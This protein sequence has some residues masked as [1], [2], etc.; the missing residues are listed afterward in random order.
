AMPAAKSE[1]RHGPISYSGGHRPRRRQGKQG[2]RCTSSPDSRFPPCSRPVSCWLRSRPQ[3]CGRRSV[4][5][6]LQADNSYFILLFRFIFI[7]QI[8][9]YTSGLHLVC[10]VLNLRGRVVLVALV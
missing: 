6:Q 3:C 5:L 10:V 8:V 9:F 4:S 7:Q 1:G 2:G